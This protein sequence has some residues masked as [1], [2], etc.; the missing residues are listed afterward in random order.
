MMSK[1][2]GNDG[3]LNR[4]GSVKMLPGFGKHSKGKSPKKARKRKRDRRKR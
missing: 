3:G 2:V 4:L 1:P